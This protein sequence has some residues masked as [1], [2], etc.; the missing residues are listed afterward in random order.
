MQDGLIRMQA[1]VTFAAA[2][3]AIRAGLKKAEELGVR[4]GIVVVDANGNMVAMARM[5]GVGGRVED[6]A[7]GKA[8]AAASLGV[9][10]AEFIEKRL[11]KNEALWRAMSARPDTFMVQGGYPLRYGGK[12]VG[13][14]GVSGARHEEDAQVAEAAAAHFA[15]QGKGAPALEGVSNR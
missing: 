6:G 5:D 3:A 13:G 7:G 8:R 11:S 4:I 2:D 15:E 1:H 14:V 10:T 12:T 9:P